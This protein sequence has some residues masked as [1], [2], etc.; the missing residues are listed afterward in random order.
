MRFFLFYLFIETV[1][2]VQFAS[3]LGGLM[4]FL[5]FIVSAI[6]GSTILKN[7][8][9]N[10]KDNLQKVQQGQISQGDFTKMHI[11]ALIGA[12]LLI[13]PGFFTDIIGI[14]LQFENFSLPFVRK[15]IKPKNEANN[16]EFRARYTSNTT[17]SSYSS[18]SFSQDFSQNQ[19]KTNQNEEIIDVEIIEQIEPDNSTKS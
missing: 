5:E 9:L 17:S 13:I 18:D 2:S 3:A 19:N 8:N 10:V 6:I 4:T 7:L 12:I 1:V 16:S 11:T 15:F 14:I